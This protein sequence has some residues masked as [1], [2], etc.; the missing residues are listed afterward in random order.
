MR[1]PLIIAL[2][3]ALSIS[4]CGLVKFNIKA[5]SQQK[6]VTANNSQSGG[7]CG[8]GEDTFD[9]FDITVSDLDKDQ[10]FL[11]KEV[12]IDNWRISLQAEVTDI[13]KSRKAGDA[14]SATTDHARGTVGI[15]ELRV[16]YDWND[17]GQMKTERI[18]FAC[19][20]AS[21]NLASPPDQIQAVINACLDDIEDKVRDDFRVAFN[22]HPDQVRLHAIATCSSDACFFLSMNLKFH[23]DGGRCSVNSTCSK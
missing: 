5:Q 19:S 15:H 3:A 10:D 6:A 22:R 9:E 20:D 12:C 1:R 11:F 2:F 13:D 16:D 23:I 4:F 7:G 18:T 17:K 21:V 8:N 14:C